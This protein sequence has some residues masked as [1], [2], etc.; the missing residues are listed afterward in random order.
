[1]H[2]ELSRSRF[3]WL[4]DDRRYAE[5]ITEVNQDIPE[6]TL[7]CDQTSVEDER[8]RQVA[9]VATSQDATCSAAR[10][11]T[12]NAYIMKY[13]IDHGKCLSAKRYPVQTNPS[14]PVALLPVDNMEALQYTM[15]CT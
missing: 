14:I 15:T 7:S 2:K 8:R 13:T 11:E 5:P 6:W 1:M 4:D 9:R 3:R 10:H 12:V